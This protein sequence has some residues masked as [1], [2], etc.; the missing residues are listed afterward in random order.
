[1]PN[2][3]MQS[4]SLLNSSRLMTSSFLRKKLRK[5][6]TKAD[7]VECVADDHQQQWADYFECN[8][9]NKV[10]IGAAAYVLHT[11]HCVAKTPQ[12]QPVESPL[13]ETT[14]TDELQCLIC[15]DIFCGSN[16][17]ESHL[18]KHS[19]AWDFKMCHICSFSSSAWIEFQEHMR[20]DHNQHE[21]TLCDLCSKDGVYSNYCELCQINVESH[22]ILLLHKREHKIMSGISKSSSTL[23]PFTTSEQTLRCIMCRNEF[24]LINQLYLHLETHVKEVELLM[25]RNAT[26]TAKVGKKQ[27]KHD[28]HICDFMAVTKLELKQHLRQIHDTNVML[29]SGSTNINIINQT[30][31]CSY[32]NKMCKTLSGLKMHIKRFHVKNY[33]T[34]DICGRQFCS[35]FEIREH[36]LTQHMNLKLFVCNVCG[37][38][39]KSRSLHRVHNET[40]LKVK[41]YLCTLC[42]KEFSQSAGLCIHIRNEHNET[43]NFP[44][45]YCGKVFE[46]AVSRYTHEYAHKNPEALTCGVCHKQFTQRSALNTHNKSR[47]PEVLKNQVKQFVCAECGKAYPVKQYLLNHMVSNV[48]NCFSSLIYS[49]VFFGYVDSLCW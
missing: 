43:K 47:H 22:D 18:M 11:R 21:N 45:R 29:P 24:A 46:K 34:C 39:S 40:H 31:Q 5:E 37:K 10:Y 28:C 38:V 44:C 49:A 35:K 27:R 25:S 6:I 12:H 32:C 42:G 17:L 16:D 1:M 9:C 8:K 19:N 41:K 30:H 7:I 15:E 33:Y 36:I 26:A 23:L 48:S 2:S 13:L 3:K 20:T 4:P 14:T